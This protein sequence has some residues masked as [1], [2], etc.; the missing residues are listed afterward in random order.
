[1]ILGS[2]REHRSDGLH[3]IVADVRWED[4]DR[5][6][7]SLHLEVDETAPL[8]L[9]PAAAAF[10]PIVAAAAHAHGERRV[11]VADPVD[12]VLVAGLE[13]ACAAFR[14]WDRS[15]R[16]PLQFEAPAEAASPPPAPGTTAV[17]LTGGIDSTASLVD[18]HRRYAEGHPRRIT[19]GLVVYGLGASTGGDPRAPDPFLRDVADRAGIRLLA[20][21][22]NL[23]SVDATV[24]FWWDKAQTALWSCVG[25]GFAPALGDIVIGSDEPITVDALYGSHPVLDDAFS[26]TSLHVHHGLLHLDRI[27]R[28]LLWQQLDDTFASLQVCN[29]PR[30]TWRP[31]NCGTCEKCVRTQLGL[32][33]IGASDQMGAFPGPPTAE[34]VRGI[35]IEAPTLTSYYISLLALLG[36]AGRPDLVDPTRAAIRRSRWYAARSVGRRFDDRVT[37]GAARFVRTA[38]MRAAAGLA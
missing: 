16:A 12:P 23:R 18:N 9:Q 1:M 2:V 13:D 35:R 6:A 3:R 28:L 31:L 26:S 11:A 37:G 8:R 4:S 25:H 7:R 29:R 24:R 30:S 15:K 38:A 32:V 17:L 22:T 14:A 33:A 34:V 10:L 27:Q 36:P 21:R 5:P 20:V 19:V